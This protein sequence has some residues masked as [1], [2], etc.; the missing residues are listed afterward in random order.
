[1]RSSAMRPSRR[2]LARGRARGVPLS[3][4]YAWVATVED[5]QVIHQPEYLDHAKALSVVGLWDQA[6]SRKDFEDVQLEAKQLL[7]A[8]QRWT[9]AT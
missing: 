2:L 7:E 6:M 4:K 1:M 3:Q 8:I 9:S 5:R